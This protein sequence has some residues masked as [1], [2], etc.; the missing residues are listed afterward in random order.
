MVL[1][2]PAGGAPVRT[3]PVKVVR[4]MAKDH[5]DISPRRRF[6]FWLATTR[7][8]IASLYVELLLI[9]QNLATQSFA[10]A[11]CYYF[12]GNTYSNIIAWF[13]QAKNDKL[14]K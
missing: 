5:S 12:D 4:H 9:P 7:C 10:G 14:K 8:V 13:L 3:L 6:G 2:H 1:T 11:M